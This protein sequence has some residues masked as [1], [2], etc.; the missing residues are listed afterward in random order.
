VA[1]LGDCSQELGRRRGGRAPPT[2]LQLQAAMAQARMRR[3]G[4]GGEVLH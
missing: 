4:E 1:R 2:G 3:G